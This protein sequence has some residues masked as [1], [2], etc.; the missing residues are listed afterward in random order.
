MVYELFQI[1]V[2][3]DMYGLGGC[4][5]LWPKAW[6][7]A[8]SSKVQTAP[9]VKQLVRLAWIGW[10]FGSQKVFNQALERMLVE[11]E[12]DGDGNLVDGEGRDLEEMEFMKAMD[13]VD[14]L[15]SCRSE[16]ITS[17]LSVLERAVYDAAA[18]RNGVSPLC[19]YNG[20]EYRQPNPKARADCHVAILGS[21]IQ[22]LAAEDLFPLPAGTDEV[23]ESAAALKERLLRVVRNIKTPGVQGDPTH[24][25]MRGCI[26]HQLHAGCSPVGQLTRQLDDAMC[27]AKCEATD[28]HVKHLE[29][30]IGGGS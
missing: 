7:A 14:H 4:L 27:G 13:L 17:L 10:V 20:A 23:F 1:A 9:N 8:V 28:A 18:N 24:R 19:R 15:A 21:I 5:G 25:A 22:C 29:R 26:S 16:L 12:A 2:S 6:C 3:V 30:E 11:V